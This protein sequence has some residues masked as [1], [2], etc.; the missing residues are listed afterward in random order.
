MT[1]KPLGMSIAIAALGLANFGAESTRGQEVRKAAAPKD[2]K[3]APAR[4]AVAK[5]P[6]ED[7]WV[8][9]FEGQVGPQFRLLVKAEMHFVRSVCEPTR[10]Q[11]QK[12][13]AGGEGA[14][15]AAIRKYA[16]SMRGRGVQSDPRAAIAEAIAKSVRETLSPEQADR[17]QKELDLRTAALKRAAVLN[18]VSSMDK[19]LVLQRDQRD[20]LREILANNWNESWSQLQLLMYGGMYFPS[21]PDDKINPILTE[22]QRT[23]WRG[24]QKGNVR[25][26][27]H[28]GMMQNVQIEDDEWDVLPPKPKP[29]Q[30][31]PTPKADSKR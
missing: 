24:A 27:F 12:I 19:M 15:N 17:Y 20:K 10:L 6:A 26:G 29:A 3:A 2:G 8:Q 16:E 5:A 25:F 9:Q 18:L 21:M 11:Y 14:V 13:L 23:I 31:Q 7:A 1:F 28:L 4:A 30:D 22:A